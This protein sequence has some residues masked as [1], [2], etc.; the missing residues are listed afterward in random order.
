MR[1]EREKPSRNYPMEA[2]SFGSQI[3]LPRSVFDRK[4][5][6]RSLRFQ[7]NYLPTYSK[8][9]TVQRYLALP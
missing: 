9:G 1:A 7:G 2:M 6:V 3:R 5:S 8:V 4:L